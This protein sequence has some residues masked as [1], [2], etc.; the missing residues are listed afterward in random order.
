MSRKTMPAAHAET[1]LSP[2]DAFVELKTLHDE[3]VR[4][5]HTIDPADAPAP[6]IRKHQQS[7][8]RALA[9]VFRLWAEQ[10][11]RSLSAMR[12]A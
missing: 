11:D 5:A 10:I 4:I 3:L 12:P 1:I 8:R 7:R 9:K 6:G 2:A